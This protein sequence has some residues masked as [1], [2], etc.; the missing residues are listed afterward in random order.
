MAS[1]TSAWEVYL[2][3]LKHSVEHAVEQ[4]YLHAKAEVEELYK[5]EA[6]VATQVVNTTVTNT[7][8]NV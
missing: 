4:V 2:N 8:A 6:N 5:T 7:Q 1:L 3:G